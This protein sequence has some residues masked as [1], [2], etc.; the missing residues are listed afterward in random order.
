MYELSRSLFINFPAGYLHDV[1][2]QIIIGGEFVLICTIEDLFKLLV[3]WLADIVS[4]GAVG[5]LFGSFQFFQ[6]FK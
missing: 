1:F 6:F 2:R 4:L 5:E 3:F